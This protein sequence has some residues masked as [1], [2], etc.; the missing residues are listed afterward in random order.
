MDE[1]HGGVAEVP[2]QKQPAVVGIAVALIALA[3]RH[4]VDAVL[5][6]MAHNAEVGEA[7]VHLFV[8][9]EHLGKPCEIVCLGVEGVAH[10]AVSAHLGTILRLTDDAAHDDERIVAE[11]LTEKVDVLCGVCR[12]QMLAVIENLTA[13]RGIGLL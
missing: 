1:R 6:G 12:A 7:H 5:R 10:T 8:H 9:V 4:S 11:D 13:V 2:Q 3:Q